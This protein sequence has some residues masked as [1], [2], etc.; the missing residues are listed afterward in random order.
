MANLG[1]SPFEEYFAAQERMLEGDQEIRLRS[2][3]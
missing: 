3:W 1:Q 2:S